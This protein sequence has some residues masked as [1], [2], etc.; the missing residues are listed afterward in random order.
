[1][2]ILILWPSGI[3]DDSSFEPIVK[4][5]VWNSFTEDMNRGDLFVHESTLRTL[6]YEYAE[7]VRPFVQDITDEIYNYYNSNF[8]FLVI[9]GSNY[10]RNDGNLGEWLPFFKRLEI[11]ILAFG[12]GAQAAS[13]ANVIELNED[14][15]EALHEISRKSVHS[16][17]VRG[18][19][20]KKLLND[21]GIKNVTVIG[22]PSIFRSKNPDLKVKY[23]G[24]KSKNVAFTTHP[25]LSGL[26]T[27]NNWNSRVT[28]VRL[29]KKLKAAGYRLK[30]L[31]QGIS[32]ETKVAYDIDREDGIR[33]LKE[34]G[35]LGDNDDFTSD[36]SSNSVCFETAND[37]YNFSATSDLNIGTRLHG[38]ITALAMGR[39]AI[40]VT[41]DTRTAELAEYFSIPTLPEDEIT[42]DFN[43]EE[44][45]ANASFSSFNR[46]FRS[47]YNTFVK[48][49]DQNNVSHRMS[50][51]LVS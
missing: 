15:V 14:V 40:F 44:F 25:Y 7:D 10:I 8:D 38:N 1:M 19:Y 32:A 22:C 39:A 50:E 2:K 6:N 13:S 24:T 46:K 17:G 47:R 27:R 36:F 30:Y 5:K 20:T 12:I 51:K 29:I 37:Y 21:L 35:W 42:D 43:V 31:T 26:Y 48:F 45:L 49:L 28:Q 9:R 18:N 34:I 33:E 3:V 16:I 11:P 4:R 41:Y 23:L